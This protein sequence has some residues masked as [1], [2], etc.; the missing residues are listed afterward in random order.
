MEDG[1]TLIGTLSSQE[2]VLRGGGGVCVLEG[3]EKE[4]ADS[5]NREMLTTNFTY[6]IISREDQL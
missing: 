1:V 2:A 3:Q 6:V 5:G 4:I